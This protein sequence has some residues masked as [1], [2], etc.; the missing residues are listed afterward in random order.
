[1]IRPARITLAIATAAVL[2]AALFSVGASTAPTTAPATL[3]AAPAFAFA[4]MD[5]YDQSCA[6]CHGPEGASYG[7][8]LGHNLDDAALVKMCH[9]MAN[10]PS[11]NPING[12]DLDTETAFHRALIMGNPFLSVTNIK[13]NVWSGEVMVDSTVTL[14]VGDQEISADVTDWNW[15]ATLPDGATVANVTITATDT[16]DNKTTTL[17]PAQSMYSNTQPIPPP[18]K[19]NH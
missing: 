17:H 10:G 5:Y 2:T 14:H 16:D 11:Q 19:R 1:M 3:P 8:G 9:D 18:E 13:G 6:R 7:P 15:T 12:R 4:A